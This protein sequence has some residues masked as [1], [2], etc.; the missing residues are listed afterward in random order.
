VKKFRVG[1]KNPVRG[2]TG[3][4]VLLDPVLGKADEFTLIV[5]DTIGQGSSAAWQVMFTGVAMTMIRQITPGR[6]AS[7]V[8]SGA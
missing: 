8:W 3:A 4:K 5:P 1:A 6:Y 2:G 7:K